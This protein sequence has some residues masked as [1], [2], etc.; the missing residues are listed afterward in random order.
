MPKELYAPGTLV[1]FNF[2]WFGRSNPHHGHQCRVI[3]SRIDVRGVHATR[4]F[5]YTLE[6]LQ[7]LPTTAKRIFKITDSSANGTT[8]IKERTVC[9]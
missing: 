5:R 8:L 9:V 6:D 7:P 2:Q 3:E 4:Y 1:R